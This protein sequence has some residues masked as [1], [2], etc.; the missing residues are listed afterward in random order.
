MYKLGA[1]GAGHMGAAILKGAVKTG[2]FKPEEIAV[3]EINPTRRAKARDR[4]YVIHK[5]AAE[6]Y[7]HCEYLLLSVL[8]QNAA[9]LLAE[10]AR[11]SPA[12][13]PVVVSIVSGM[14]SSFIRRMLGAETKVIN[15]VPN[16]TLSVGLGA[17]AVSH[18]GNVTAEIL[19][20]VLQIFDGLGQTAVVDEKLLREI[21]AANG[22]APGFAFYM[23]DAVAK[24]A[25]AH[26]VDY[27]L[28]LKMTA[29][30]FEGA[31]KMAL[32][33]GKSAADLLEQVCSPG[34]LTEKGVK[35]FDEHK[36][37]EIIMNGAWE[38]VKRGYE[39]AL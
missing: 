22:C 7:E 30:A 4:G 10:L 29:S 28:A 16:I 15:V 21:I 19:A 37:N 6:V 36:L 11:C 26:G 32:E 35:Y 23:M 25:E 18:T 8:P 39:L 31:A 3:C 14:G 1:I 5:D 13:M 38:S 17:T 33:S 2:V 9:S 12:E 20:P 27:K 24:A 34:G